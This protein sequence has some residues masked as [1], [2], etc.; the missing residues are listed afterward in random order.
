MDPKHEMRNKW[1][2]CTS[3]DTVQNC[4]L[5]TTAMRK[6]TAQCQ[7]LYMDS[8]RFRKKTKSN[9]CTCLVRWSFCCRCI[10]CGYQLC[11]GGLVVRRWTC[12][13]VGR[14]FESHRLRSCLHNNLGQVVHTYLPLPSSSIT[15][16]WLKDNDVLRLGRWLQAWQKVMAVCCR[17]MT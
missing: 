3:K 13:H 8:F 14:E 5:S 11:Q 9:S 10:W 1:W 7:K 2:K 16:Y 15:W 17:G 6:L 4:S 12:D